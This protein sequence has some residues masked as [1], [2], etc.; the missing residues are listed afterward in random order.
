MTK[1]VRTPTKATGG[2][3]PEEIAR[4]KD[5]TAM[6]IARAFRTEPIEPGK[7]IPAI[8]GLYEVSGLKKPRVIIVPSPLVMAFAYGASAAIWHERKQSA[9]DIA[10]YT[11][12]AAAT[13]A[14]TRAAT[15]RATD[16][17]TY[18]ATD[19][20][21]R[22]ATDIATDRATDIATHTATDIATAAATR[23]A[24][25]IATEKQFE[26]G[27]A[28]ACFELAGISGINC[29][30]RWFTVYHAGNMWAAYD[31]YITAMRDIIGLRLPQYDKYHFWE[32][33]AIHGGFRVMHDE[34]CVVCDFPEFIRVD[35][36]NRSHCESGPSHRWRDGWSLYH[37]HGV[38]IPGEW[39][40]DRK[41]LTAAV[42]LKWENIEQRRAACEI[43]GWS[44]ILKELN[45]KVI[46]TDDPEIGE[47]VEVTLPD[48]GKERFLRVLCGTGREFALPV[49]PFMK[50]AL[51]AQAWTWGM[52]KKSFIVPEVR[53]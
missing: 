49:P 22:A 4:M 31:C 8:E 1:I 19:R 12:T 7:I 36:E 5:H 23:A 35:A 40:E 2:V 9:T 33:A 47:L 41:S 20:A 50:T 48:S 45:A 29:A 34:F 44:A 51:E 53:T 17:A 24:T 3:T 37:W 18:T 10:T 27:A 14:A 52:D 13:R 46:N 32:Q 30:E 38:S 42:A 25:D 11:A 39:I 21:T 43:L 6:W 16:I 15:D 28:A 26:N